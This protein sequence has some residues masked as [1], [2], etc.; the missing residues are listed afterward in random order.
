[1]STF[2]FS[3]LISCQQ[4]VT[5][6]PVIPSEDIG[7]IY[8]PPP[9]P[10]VV[11]PTICSEDMVFVSNGK[12]CIDKYEWP[13]KKNTL[14]DF[15]MTAF[16]AEKLCESIKKRLCTH[17]EWLNACLGKDSLRYGYGNFWQK[18][19]CNDNTNT[20]YI[21]VNWGKMNEGRDAWKSYAKTLYK[22]KPSGSMEQ[23][24]VSEANDRVYDM[25][26][27][28]REWVRDPAGY[29]GYAFESS[30]WHGTMQ[31]PQGCGF[32]VRSHA[33]EFASYEVGTRCCKE[34]NNV[35]DNHQPQ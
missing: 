20:K 4:E 12:F 34:T 16:E 17:T 14:P 9:T 26:G 10:P 35:K 27:N 5:P 23:C 8:I 28:V 19:A 32:V 18:D 3:L 29:G 13:N 15:A 7:A 24:F 31:G 22:G 11:Q 25:I 33:P 21:P 1:M 6:A 2:L 30:F